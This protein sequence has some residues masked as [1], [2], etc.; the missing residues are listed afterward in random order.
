M[1]DS[2]WFGYDI[3]RQ[4]INEFK[5]I[6]NIGIVVNHTSNIISI[7]KEKKLIEVHLGD[8]P[9]YVKKIFVPELNKTISVKMSVKAMKIIDKLGLMPYLKKQGLTIQDNI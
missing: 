2:V 6:L 1:Q 5:D 9:V 3:Y 8:K 4:N 7:N